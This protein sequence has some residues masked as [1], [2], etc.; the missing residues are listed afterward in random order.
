MN[1]PIYEA[2]RKYQEHSTAPDLFIDYGFYFMISAAL[3]RR[4]W[5][6]RNGAELYPNIYVVLIA[7]PGVGKGI[8]V[9]PVTEILRSFKKRKDL[10]DEVNKIIQSTGADAQSIVD[11]VKLQNDVR[12]LV[13]PAAADATTYQALV[14]DNAQALTPYR[15]DKG[16][17]KKGLYTHSSMYFS[18][19]EMAS[20]FQQDQKRLLDYLLDAYD[21]GDHRYKIKGNVRG[22]EEDCV[23]RTCVSILAG[24]NPSW[25]ADSTMD[26]IIGEGFSSRSFFVYAPAA[27]RYTFD[28]IEYREDNLAAKKIV[29]EH[30]RKLTTIFGGIDYTPEAHEFLSNYMTEEYPGELARADKN[31]EPYFGRKAVHLKKMCL[32]LH[33]SERADF[34]ESISLTTAQRAFNA[35]R[36]MEASMPAAFA[37]RRRNPLS[38]PTQLLTKLIAT[39]KGGLTYEAILI[40]MHGE[41]GLEELKEIIEYLENSK[42]IKKDKEGKYHITAAAKHKDI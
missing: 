8:I 40:G 28:N 31:I 41:V 15:Y 37:Y 11:A 2:W 4:V 39:S 34:E 16:D 26:K 19:T 22:G 36:V 21:C 42:Q 18:L 23:F 24:T 25:I 1:Y 30:V 29:V 32:V 6:G 35:L 12:N 38:A 20:L 5:L 13:L 14:K 17:G 27:R 3:Q 9:K 7:P 10:G 33:F